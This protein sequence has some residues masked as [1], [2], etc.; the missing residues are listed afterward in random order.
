REVAA[1]SPGEHVRAILSVDEALIVSGDR[2][3]SAGREIPGHSVH[4][5]SL[6]LFLREDQH[7]GERS[8]SRRAGPLDVH[9]ESL[10]GELVRPD[11]YLRRRRAGINQIMIR[12]RTTH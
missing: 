9:L 11:D 4:V 1:R 7:R 2:D 3:V 10:A 6:R 8:Y 12:L 5:G